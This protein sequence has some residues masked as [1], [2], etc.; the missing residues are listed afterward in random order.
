M[1][2]TGREIQGRCY[3]GLELPGKGQPEG[4]EAEHHDEQ[5]H[6]HGHLLEPRNL[7]RCHRQHQHHQQP[8]YLQQRQERRCQRQCSGWWTDLCPGLGLRLRSDDDVNVLFQHSMRP[9]QPDS[10]TDCR[11]SL[12]AR[13]WPLAVKLD[14]WRLRGKEQFCPGGTIFENL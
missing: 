13:W 1:S 5:H 14:H 10:I 3:Q 9:I 2:N 11:L 12:S 6:P 4:P 7:H 8:V